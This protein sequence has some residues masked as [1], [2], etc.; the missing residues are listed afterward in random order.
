MF[1]EYF[2]KKTLAERDSFAKDAGS[3]RGTL[4]LVAYGHKQIDLGLADVICAVSGNAITLADLP[5]TDRARQQHQTRS[6]VSV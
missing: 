4:T 1:K 2:F 6:Q 3:T 5:L